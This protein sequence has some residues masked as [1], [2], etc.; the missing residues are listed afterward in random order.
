MA[1]SRGAVEVKAK[2]K[3]NQALYTVLYKGICKAYMASAVARHQA[4]RLA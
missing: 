4:A 3:K 2:K 1:L